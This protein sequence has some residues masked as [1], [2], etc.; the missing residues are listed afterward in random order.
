MSSSFFSR[1]GTSRSLASALKVV[2]IAVLVIGLVLVFTG[3]GKA[4]VVGKW[5]NAEQGTMEFTSDGKL[6]ACPCASTTLADLRLRPF[7]DAW[8]ASDVLNARREAFAARAT[9]SA[10]P[11]PVPQL[12][13]EFGAPEG[14]GRGKAR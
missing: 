3:C 8:A 1:R 10:Q 12:K 6:T 13:L 4:S 5:N 2:G 9:A 11:E 14:R 7:R